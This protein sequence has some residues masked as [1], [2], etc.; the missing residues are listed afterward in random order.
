[1]D[2]LPWRRRVDPLADKYPGWSPYNYTLNNPLS[3]VDLKGDSVTTVELTNGQ[4][5]VVDK[6]IE[7]SVKELDEWAKENNIP[8]VIND[9][10]R[11]TKEQK[12]IK[13][14]YGDKAAEPR[15][16]RHESGFALDVQTIKW[17]K[18]QKAK[19]EK[20]ANSLNIYPNEVKKEPWH[21]QTEPLEHGYKSRGAVINE[22]QKHYSELLKAKQKD[23]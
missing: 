22:N 10:F 3:F 8:M 23:N 19:F 1:M 4:T 12:E 21:Y 7:E 18:N 6:K 14:K 5:I 17:T 16:S 20:K 15:T 9:D 11:T 2:Y 13:A